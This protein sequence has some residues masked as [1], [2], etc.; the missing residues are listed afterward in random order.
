MRIREALFPDELLVV[1]SLFEEY[2]AG[3]DID[4]CFQGF[5]AELDAVPGRYARPAG[6]VWLAEVAGAVA[7]CVA[8]RPLDTRWGEMKRLYV[9][10]A[11]RGSG[12][13][14]ALAE[15]VLI[16]GAEL[17]YRRICLDTLPSMGGAIALYRLLGFVEIEPYCHNPTPGALFLGRDL[18]TPCAPDLARE[19]ESGS[20]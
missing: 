18:G 19:S 4:L 12:A 1:R 8:L 9:R 17:G 11:F 2:A 5:A 16:A 6:G 14:R 7:G 3:L 20:S 13:G 10:P 15:Q